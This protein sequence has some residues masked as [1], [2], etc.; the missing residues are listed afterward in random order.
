[1]Q[2]QKPAVEAGSYA[3]FEDGKKIIFV[4]FGTDSLY[5]FN[6]TAVILSLILTGNGVLQLSMGNQFGIV[7]LILAFLGWAALTKSVKWAKNAKEKPL[8]NQRITAILDLEKNE[9][10]NG[11]N[12]LIAPLSQVDIK[13]AMQV[14]SSSPSLVAVIKGKKTLTLVKGNALT[15]GSHQVFSYLK[16]KGLLK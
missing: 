6:F 8:K 16:E 13:K 2:N 15:G 5:I 11:K 4:D 1:M 3:I 9:L 10:L 12:E 14:T 7:M